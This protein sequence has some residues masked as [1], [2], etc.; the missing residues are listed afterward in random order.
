MIASEKNPSKPIDL[1]WLYNLLFIVPAV[2]LMLFGLFV[3]MVT[4]EVGHIPTYSN[5]NPKN[6]LFG[7]IFQ[8]ILLGSIPMIIVLLGTGLIGLV[9]EFFGV[10]MDKFYKW[11]VAVCFV[12]MPVLIMVWKSGLT[13]WLVD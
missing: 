9:A 11:R 2:W 12:V 8:P 5:P 13:E 3:L 1:A 4:L 10:V 7:A 6:T